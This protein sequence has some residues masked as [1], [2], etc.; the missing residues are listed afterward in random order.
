MSNKPIRLAIADDHPMVISGIRNMLHYYKHLEVTDTYS[1]GAALME[2]LKSGQPDILLLDLQLPDISGNELIR[3]ITQQYPTISILVVTSMES[4][5]HIKDAMRAGSKGYLLKTANRETL[6]E[7]IETIQQGGEYLEP[8]LKEQ[9]L[10]DMLKR[11]SVSAS[12]LTR[13]EKEILGLISRELSSPEIAASLSISVRTVENHRFSL[14]QKL[15]AKNTVSLIR[16]AQEK[17]YL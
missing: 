2:G 8:S 10:Q 12:P 9:L 6:L 3:L 11:K 1:S 7:A 14:M 16:I 17:G 15:N 4:A 13:R 5:F